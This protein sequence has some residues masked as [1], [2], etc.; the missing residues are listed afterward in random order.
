MLDDGR[1]G[2]E[3]KASSRIDAAAEWRSPLTAVVLAT[4]LFASLTGLAIELLPFSEL[5][6]LGVLMH[7]LVGACMIVPLVWYVAR[8][9]WVRRAGKLSHYQLLG[10]ILLA[11]LTVCV[12]S[13]LVVTV[14]GLIGPRLDRVWD[15]LHLISGLAV[16]VFLG[17]HLAMVLVRRINNPLARRDLRLAQ[18][19]CLLRT[20]MVCGVLLASCV[21]WS[22]LH[23]PPSVITSFSDDYD[24]TFGEDRPFAPSLARLEQVR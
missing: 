21:A 20:A 17:V 10:Y 4:L 15:T 13:G 12:V 3:R 18:G 2:G 6:Q 11:L 14:Q 5:M 19:S 16:P 7:T 23:E 22:V 24:W 8:H 9:W 1:A